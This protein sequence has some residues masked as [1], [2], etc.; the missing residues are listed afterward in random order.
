MQ[1]A[2]A[3]Y[4]VQDW[5]V[6]E[7]GGLRIGVFGIIGKDAA[8]DAPFASPVTFSDPI[9]AATD[10]VKVLREKENVDIVI[11]LSHSGTNVDRSHSEDEILAAKVP[12]IDV[13]VSGHT[14]TVLNKPIVVGRTHIVAA[15]SD[16]SALGI[17]KS[18]VDNKNVSL[19]SYSV[20]LFD[21][22]SPADAA[23]SELIPHYEVKANSDYLAP[24]GDQATSVIAERAFP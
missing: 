10:T 4:G 14:H 3:A 19:A 5:K 9:Q 21:S 20:Q 23:M 22:R 12:G 16:A 8:G 24:F 13:I 11:A 2:F 18:N 17:L 15:G 7:R 1:K 6:V